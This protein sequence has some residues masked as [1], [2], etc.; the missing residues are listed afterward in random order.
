MRIAWKDRRQAVLGP[1]PP[2]L[3]H[4]TDGSLESWSSVEKLKMFA[5]KPRTDSLW[6]APRGGTT[7]AQPRVTL[8]LGGSGCMGQT[9]HGLQSHL[10]TARS[11]E[12]DRKS[13]V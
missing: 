3:A 5:D 12:Q 10:F 7:A 2:T 1:H 9:L 4:T 6:P 8:P 11:E 13:V